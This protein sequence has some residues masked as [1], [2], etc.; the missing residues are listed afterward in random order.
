MYRATENWII[1]LFWVSAIKP[2]TRFQRQPHYGY[3]S[4][5]QKTQ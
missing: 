1:F 5:H 4:I 2:T 3:L